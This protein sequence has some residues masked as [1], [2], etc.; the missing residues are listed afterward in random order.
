MKADLFSL[1]KHFEENWISNS[2]KRAGEEVRQSFLPN[3][4]ET[5]CAPFPVVWLNSGFPGEH[6]SCR[7]SEA[8]GELGLCFLSAWQHTWMK[9][10]VSTMERDPPPSL[11]PEQYQLSGPDFSTQLPGQ[12]QVALSICSDEACGWTVPSTTQPS[13][14]HTHT[15]DT[16]TAGSLKAIQQ[17]DQR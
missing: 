10:Q 14:T 15:S 5:A 16:H 6:C 17:L 7:V 4:R 1:G 11:S 13:S 2:L 8:P 3:L 12:S 9:P